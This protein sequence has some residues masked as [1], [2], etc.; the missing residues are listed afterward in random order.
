[1]VLMHVVKGRQ[2]SHAHNQNNSLAFIASGLTGV[3]CGGH[4]V[5]HRSDSRSQ[6]VGAVLYS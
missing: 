1:M 4:L 2:Y 5:V 3:T 6:R